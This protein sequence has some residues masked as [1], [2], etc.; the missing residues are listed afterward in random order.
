MRATA[1][2]ANSLAWQGTQ[3]STRR[4]LLGHIHAHEERLDEASIAIVKGADSLIIVAQGGAVV[5]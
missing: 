5:P 2:I 3:P 4:E 1:S